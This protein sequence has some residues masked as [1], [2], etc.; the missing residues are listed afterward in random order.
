MFLL[1]VLPSVERYVLTC[2]IIETHK[3]CGLPARK[4]EIA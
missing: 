1:D 4:M 3:A 2:D